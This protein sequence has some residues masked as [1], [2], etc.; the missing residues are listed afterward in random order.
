MQDNGH[1]DNAYKAQ[2]YER[3]VRQW[4]WR[5][6]NT[7]FV[8]ILFCGM[9]TWALS[10]SGVPFLGAIAWAN[11]TDK[12]IQQAVAPIQSKVDQIAAQ[13]DAIKTQQSTRELSDLR[14]KLFETRVAQ[15]KARTKGID[16]G[17]P[18]SIRMGELQNLHY[19][20][21]KTYYLAPDCSDL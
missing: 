13:T 4:R 15:C 21:T 10:P 14:Q 2:N 19:V 6:H 5:V 20:L 12:K 3:C 17:N 16:A 7:L 9:V 8:M 11:D 1:A 18:Y